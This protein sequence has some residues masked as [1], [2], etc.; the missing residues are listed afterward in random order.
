MPLET[1]SF[2]YWPLM[3]VCIDIEMHD[4]VFGTSGLVWARLA[5]LPLVFYLSKKIRTALAG[6]DDRRLHAHLQNVI[7][8]GGLSALTPIAYVSMKGSACVLGNWNAPD[9]SA[10]CGGVVEP[11]LGV[12]FHLTCFFGYGACFSPFLNIDLKK[13]LELKVPIVI[14]FHI[15]LITIER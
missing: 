6:L 1:V 4:G 2:L 9:I 3:L 15:L 13:I 11:L 7:W 8:A 10:E 12:A 14:K 5:L